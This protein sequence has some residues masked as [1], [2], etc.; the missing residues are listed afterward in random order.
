MHLLCQ[1]IHSTWQWHVLKSYLGVCDRQ[2]GHASSKRDKIL[3][4]LQ[5]QFGKLVA[6]HRKAA[7]PQAL[8]TQVVSLACWPDTD[9]LLHAMQTTKSC[10]SD[11]RLPKVM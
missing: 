10:C 2:S 8:H 11:S 3:L 1:Q 7:P 4:E 5:P 6:V 9:I